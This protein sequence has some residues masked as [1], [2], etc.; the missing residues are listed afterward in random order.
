[1]QYRLGEFS[2]KNLEMFVGFFDRV[3]YS[4]MDVWDLFPSLV[5]ERDV[6]HILNDSI[7][8]VN[9]VSLVGQPELHLQREVLSHN[10]RLEPVLL[11]IVP[12]GVGSP[13]KVRVQGLEISGHLGGNLNAGSAFVGDWHAFPEVFHM[14]CVLEHGSVDGP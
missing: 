10:P 3:P 7:V 13:F 2:R 4:W 8:G 9:P 5:E 1:M 12:H 6:D 11:V 14:G